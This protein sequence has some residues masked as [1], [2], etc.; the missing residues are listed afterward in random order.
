MP[1][2]PEA[3]STLPAVFVVLNAGSGSEAHDETREA[4]VAVLEEAG[5]PH[6]VFVAGGG[7]ELSRRA[8]EA[9]AQ[10]RS[11]AGAAIVAAAGGDGTINTVAQ[12]V[13]DQAPH[14]P[15]GVI[16]QGTFNYFARAHGLPL[17]TAAATRL[18][19]AGEAQ[20]VQVGRVNG[21]VF[22]VNASL[23]LYPELLENR[24]EWKQKL[25]RSRGVAFLAGLWSLLGEHRQLSIRLET[26]ALARDFRT[27]TLFVGN[28]PLQLERIGL[29][30]SEAVADGQLAAILLKPIG[31]L[32]MLGLLLRGALGRLGEAESVIS[33]AFNRLTVRRLG[34]G[35]PY[36]RGRIKVAADGEVGWLETPLVF[37]SS[38][39][40]LRL[41]KALPGAEP[42]APD[43]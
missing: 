10:A 3:P 21:K 25:G 26:D 33:L 28:N 11:H 24:E 9:V 5:C 41:I 17:E 13:L 1:P 35:L 23:G 12:A 7:G 37:Q 34:L 39:Q 31:T 6:Q 14:L 2:S 20:P 43:E 18:L 29:P 30:V 40:P 4:I 27:P 19:L 15:F 22:L 16:A 32:A 38:P 42:G 36:R 8:A